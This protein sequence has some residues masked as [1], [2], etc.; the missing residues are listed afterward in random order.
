M[1]RKSDLHES[2]IV[3]Y[4]SFVLATMGFE[5]PERVLDPFRFRSCMLFATRS[6]GYYTYW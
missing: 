1:G 5:N 4:D 6:F 2:A 3:S